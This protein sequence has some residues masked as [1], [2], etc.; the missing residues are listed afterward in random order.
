MNYTDEQ[1]RA[2]QR[3]VDETLK[4]AHESRGWITCEW[5]DC[6]IQR[7]QDQF[8]VYGPTAYKLFPAQTIE[9]PG[10]AKIEYVPAIAADGRI[11]AMWPEEGRGGL[12][13]LM[14]MVMR[15]GRDIENPEWLTIFVDGGW[16][17]TE[18]LYK[19]NREIL[20]QLAEEIE[21]GQN[22]LTR[23]PAGWV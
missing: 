21:D 12:M 9:E 18:E 15:R 4:E 2:I 14:R 5:S 11:L 19:S 23:K 7:G 3:G 17:H 22:I 10:M 20:E 13:T 8:A 16:L 6:V 1:L